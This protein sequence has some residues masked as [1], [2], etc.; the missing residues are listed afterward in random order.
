MLGDSTVTATIAVK[1][2]N[3][4]KEFYQ[5]TL[6]LKQVDENPGGVTYQSGASKLFVYPSGYAGTNQATCAS[7]EVEDLAA[8]VQALQ[9]Q[10]VTFE[11]YDIPDTEK[12][13]DGVILVMAGEKA[14]W[15]KDPDGNILAVSTQR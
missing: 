2:L 9:Q 10:G 7:W 13:A 12:E 3:A 1:D 11:R 4:A 6:G 15:F 5:N 8:A 14:A